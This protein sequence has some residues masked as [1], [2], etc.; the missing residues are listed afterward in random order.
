MSPADVTFVMV[1]FVMIVGCA[2]SFDWLTGK[3][4]GT[5]FH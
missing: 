3:R 1:V 2:L 5:R 4:H